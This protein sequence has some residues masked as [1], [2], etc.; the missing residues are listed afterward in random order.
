MPWRNDCSGPCAQQALRCHIFLVNSSG[1]V[2]PVVL[3]I[4]WGCDGKYFFHPWTIWSSPWKTDRPIA[5]AGNGNVQ[6]V[7]ACWQ[8][9]I[10]LNDCI[11]RCYWNLDLACNLPLCVLWCSTV[12]LQCY[13][14]QAIPME[15]AK[16]RPS[17][18]LYSLDRS[19][20]NL[21]WLIM[22]V[23]PTRM[24]ILVEFGWVGNSPQIRE[25]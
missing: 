12:V 5:S 21:V 15:Q 9:Q 1:H 2:H 20:P 6:V 7:L 25:I 13:R 18:T 14:R 23:T 17:V 3:R 11:D 22:S 19:L 8:L 4:A 24:P 10:L 16:I